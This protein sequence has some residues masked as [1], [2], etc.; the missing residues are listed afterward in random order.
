[1]LMTIQSKNNVPML[2]LPTLLLGEQRQRVNRKK[3]QNLVSSFIYMPINL[4]ENCNVYNLLN[5]IQLQKY[6]EVK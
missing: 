2:L 6:Q 4:K 5:K 3:S 1:M